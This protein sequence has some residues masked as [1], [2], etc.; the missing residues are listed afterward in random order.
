MWDWFISFMTQVLAGIEGFCGD[1]GLAVII[2]TIIIRVC[3]VP[4]MNKQTALYCSHAG[5]PAKDS[6]D[7]GKVC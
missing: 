6:G 2:L 1:W 5:R 7:S 4:L 3:L